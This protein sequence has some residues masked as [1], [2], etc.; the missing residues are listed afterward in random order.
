MDF[1]EALKALKAGKRVARKGWNGKGLWVACEPVSG[2]ITSHEFTSK[3]SH[4]ILIIKNVNDTFATWVPS[5]TDLFAED[6][7]VL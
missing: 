3:L 5:I 7:E 2:K 1:S 4:S 6:W